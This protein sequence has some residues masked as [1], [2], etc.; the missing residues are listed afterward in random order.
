MERAISDK[1]RAVYAK[2]AIVPAKS[3]KRTIKRDRYNTVTKF[4]I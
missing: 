2:S 1:K 3:I 4:T